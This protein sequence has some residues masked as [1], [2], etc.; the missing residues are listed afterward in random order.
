MELLQTCFLYNFL[1]RLLTSSLSCNTN[2]NKPRRRRRRTKPTK[3]TT[4]PKMPARFPELGIQ[5]S[6]EGSGCPKFL[7]GKVFRQNSTLLENSS[8]IFRQHEM[9]FLPRFGHFPSRKMAAGRS[10]PPS[11]IFSSETATTFLTVSE[12]WGYKGE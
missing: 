10:A 12:R 2:T 6:R 3:P 1:S 11:W 4:R 7:A 9:L 5:K 8:P